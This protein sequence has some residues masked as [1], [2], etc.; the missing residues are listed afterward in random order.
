MENTERLALPL[1]APGQAQKEVLHNEALQLVDMLVA[2]AVEEAPRDDP[3]QSLA[4]GDCYIAGDAPTGAWSG[5]PQHICAYTSAGWR[6]AAPANGLRAFVKST[7]TFA[8]YGPAGWVVGSLVGERLLIGGVQ[9]VGPQASGIA[10][11]AGGTTVDAEAR[12]SIGEIIAALRQHGLI[13]S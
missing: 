11:P 3:P 2:S 9:V 12:T 6:F 1:L 10:D 4:A 13:S 8:E 5:H 7:G